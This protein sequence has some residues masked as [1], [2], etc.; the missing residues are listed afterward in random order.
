MF[1]FFH[2][3]NLM[4]GGDARASLSEFL[5]FVCTIIPAGQKNVVDL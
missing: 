5:I 2:I 3:Q 1:L 4:K